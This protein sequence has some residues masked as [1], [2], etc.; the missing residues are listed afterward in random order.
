M[1][2]RIVKI[3]SI[4]D[5]VCIKTDQKKAVLIEKLNEIIQRYNKNR[6]EKDEFHYELVMVTDENIRH[7]LGLKNFILREI[8]GTALED[9]FLKKFVHCIS[10]IK[11]FTESFLSQSNLYEKINKIYNKAYEYICYHHLIDGFA[12]RIDDTPLYNKSA[13]E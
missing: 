13:Q 7:W 8:A 1:S 2:K 10:Y 5:F 11:I 6:D 3:K 12:F 9:I 4:I